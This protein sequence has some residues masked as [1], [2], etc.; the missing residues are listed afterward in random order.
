MEHGKPIVLPFCYIPTIHPAIFYDDGNGT[1]NYVL[2]GS[3]SDYTVAYSTQAAFCRTKG[4]RLATKTTTPAVD[5]YVQATKN[6]WYPASQ[7]LR[8]QL[9]FC[10]TDT[11]V[12]KEITFSLTTTDGTTLKAML[13]QCGVAQNYVAI[14]V[15]VATAFQLPGAQWIRFNLGWNYLDLSADLS[16]MYYKTLALN[17]QVFDI[18]QHQVHTAAIGTEPRA[19]FTI[20]L[21]TKEAAI[22]IIYVSDILI[23]PD[24]R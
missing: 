10:D 20:L 22:S 6:F 9:L 11:T 12:D 21:T 8:I 17:H 19:C 3:G 16:S 14:Y 13:V 4:L 18:S 7:R 15:P 24:L 1:A 2:A 23:T 5:D